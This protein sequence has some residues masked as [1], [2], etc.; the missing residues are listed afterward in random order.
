M[1]NGNFGRLDNRIQALTKAFNE[2]N[3]SLQKYFAEVTD[4]LG[5]VKE[6]PEMMGQLQETVSGQ[7]SNLFEHHMK[8]EFASRKASIEAASTE[9]EELEAFMER[10][11]KSLETDTD[12]VRRRYVDLLDDLAKETE[13]R[14]RSLDSHAFRIV[15][16]IYP[17]QVQDRFS[18]LSVPAVRRLAE[19]A[20]EAADERNLELETRWQE[21]REAVQ[22]YLD[23][24]RGWR[25]KL[26]SVATDRKGEGRTLTLQV[27][28]AEIEDEDGNRERRLVVVREGDAIQLEELPDELS[29]RIERVASDQLEAAGRSEMAEDQVESLADAVADRG[30]ARQRWWSLVEDPPGWIGPDGEADSDEEGRHGA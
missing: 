22:S 23:T 4:G 9:A 13:R 24:S 17:E 5:A 1:S 30:V 2:L 16:E 18:R 19:E 21:T 7:F 11:Q 28:V 10:K 15:E 12:R 14:V 25:E 3:E 27:L 29:E 8:A 26:R 20:E 6:L